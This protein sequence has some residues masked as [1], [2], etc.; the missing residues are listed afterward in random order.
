MCSTFYAD[1]SSKTDDGITLTPQH[2]EACVTFVTKTS[3]I[4]R[5]RGKCVY[6]DASGN[7]LTS[8]HLNVVTARLPL[9]GGVSTKVI[10]FCFSTVRQVI[11][12]H[13]VPVVR[14]FFTGN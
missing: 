9:S 3:S 12:A 10:R 14:P 5:H 2:I 8:K 6:R 7:T 11:Y 13:K 1:N 4:K